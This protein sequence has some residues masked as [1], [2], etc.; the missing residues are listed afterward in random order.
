MLQIFFYYNN[1]VRRNRAKSLS[2]MKLLIFMNLFK[3]KCGED[4]GT[5]CLTELGGMDI[6]GHIVPNG[7]ELVCGTE[8]V[9]GLSMSNR[10]P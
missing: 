3:K 1:S 9:L 6:M 2:F 5:P 10:P 7:T 8:A 4:Q